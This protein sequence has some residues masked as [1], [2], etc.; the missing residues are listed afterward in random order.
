[1]HKVGG[2]EERTARLFERATGI[3]AAAERACARARAGL[4][5]RVRQ[6]EVGHEHA[7][8]HWRALDSANRPVAPCLR[9]GPVSFW[10]VT[11]TCVFSFL[12]FFR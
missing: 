5:T 11:K 3:L 6:R 9:P 1:M 7:C 12:G 2:W 4:R 10:Y 8:S